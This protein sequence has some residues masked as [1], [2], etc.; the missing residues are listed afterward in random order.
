MGLERE[1]DDVEIAQQSQIVACI[2]P[3]RERAQI[4]LDTKAVAADGGEMLPARHDCDRDSGLSQR[5][6]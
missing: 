5:R 3:H 2:D 4:A 6:R 1:D